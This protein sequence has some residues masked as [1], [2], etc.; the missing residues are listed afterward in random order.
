[1][2]RRR[3]NNSSSDNNNNNN[4]NNNDDDDDDDNDETVKKNDWKK[5]GVPCSYID[6]PLFITIVKLRLWPSKKE[7]CLG[8]CNVFVFSHGLLV[9]IDLVGGIFVYSIFLITI[10]Q[11][12]YIQE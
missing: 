5:R 9:I 12:K 7:T 6:N 4:N 11:Q 2:Q 10:K 8:T 1:M 3:H